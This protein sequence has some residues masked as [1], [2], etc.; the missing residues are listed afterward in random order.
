M[1]RAPLIACGEIRAEVA[2]ARR[3]DVDKRFTDFLDGFEAK[4]SEYEGRLH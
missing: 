1:D 4:L 2:I 3:L